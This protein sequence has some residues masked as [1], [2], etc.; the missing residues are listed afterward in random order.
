M[1]KGV[2]FSHGYGKGVGDVDVILEWM[3]SNLVVGGI[4]VV[5]VW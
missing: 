4:D 3:S 1:R 2:R 5:R